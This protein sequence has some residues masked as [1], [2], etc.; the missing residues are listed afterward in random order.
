MGAPMTAC[1]SFCVPSM[2]SEV[3]AGIGNRNMPMSKEMI[4]FL[5]RLLQPLCLVRAVGATAAKATRA[6]SRRARPPMHYYPEAVRTAWQRLDRSPVLN[7]VPSKPVPEVILPTGRLQL[8]GGHLDYVGE[9]AWETHFTDTEESDSLHRWN[10]LLTSVVELP[11]AE[12]EQ[13]GLALVHSWVRRRAEQSTAWGGDPYSTGERVSNFCLFWSLLGHRDS[14]GRL[15]DVPEDIHAALHGMAVSLADRLEYSGEEST[16]N[17]ALN[18]ARALFFAG[19]FLGWSSGTEL[20]LAIMQERLPKL[21]TADGFLREGSSHYHF[22]FSRWVLEMLWVADQSGHGSA[23]AWLRQFAPRLVER[24]WFFLVPQPGAGCWKMPLVG[25][26]SP[27]FLPDWLL[28]LPWSAIALRE[29]HPVSLPEPPLTRGWA[30][31][32]PEIAGGE[33]R[34]AAGAMSPMQQ[35]YPRSHW[36]RLDCHDWTL[37]IHAG[38]DDGV[39]RASHRHT[40]LG[41]FSLFYRGTEVFADCG[42][43]SYSKDD[44]L[45]EYGLSARSHN[46]VLLDGCGP[47]AEMRLSRLPPFY[48]AVK[49][50]TELCESDGGIILTLSND[51]FSRLRGRTVVHTRTFSLGSG[52]FSVEDRVRG[53]GAHNAQVIFQCGPDVKVA[54]TPVA[55]CFELAVQGEKPA[56]GRFGPDRDVAWDV[57]SSVEAGRRQNSS[58]ASGW[59]S[60]IYG[61]VMPCTTLTFTERVELPW[62]CRHT[63]NWEVK[64][65]VA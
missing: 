60:R 24:C 40:D 9:P 45:G 25:D 63:L 12:W 32:W 23:A 56:R 6:L 7:G 20:A 4:F 35:S 16:G 30:G 8:A 2:C 49:V 36:L 14:A 19:Q 26:V 61:T 53:S 37:F 58:M 59:I 43:A 18:N 28:A 41:A 27:D 5:R 50:S 62:Q 44:P 39:I 52:R 29:F 46:T 65:C 34:R 31:L 57:T 38:S 42:R 3:H 21:V 51:G 15:T 48:R 54:V 64:P 22:L 1:M 47:M 17:H 33:T 55:G 10:W 13:T 11:K